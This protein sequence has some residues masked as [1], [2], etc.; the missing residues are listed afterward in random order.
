MEIE[1]EKREDREFGKRLFSAMAVGCTPWFVGA[2]IAIGFRWPLWA[3]LVV[4]ATTMPPA[5]IVVG[6]RFYFANCPQCGQRI[7]IPRKAYLTGEPLRYRCEGC[8]IEWTT[9]VTPGGY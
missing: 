2:V 9:T 1:F 7:G 4:L 6:R 8:R 3:W 5:L